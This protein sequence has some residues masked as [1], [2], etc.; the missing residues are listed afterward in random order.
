MKK[1]LFTIALS[2]AATALATDS[3]S[4]LYNGTNK[5]LG[6]PLSTSANSIALSS[7]LQNK[8]FSY[9][10]FFD[11]TAIK[12][13]LTDTTSTTTVLADYTSTGFDTSYAKTAWT[14]VCDST[15][16]ALRATAGTSSLTSTKVAGP[17][18]WTNLTQLALTVSFHENGSSYASS[19]TLTT[20][21]QATAD[22]TATYKS[23][24]STVK[25]GSSAW[26]FANK[27]G[28]TTDNDYKPSTL[29]LNTSY[30]NAAYVSSDGIENSTSRTTYA[31]NL[32]STYNSIP[33][34][35][36]ATLSLLALAGLAARRRRK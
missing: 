12:E 8:D 23:T 14:L 34:P 1:T 18:N 13:L 27:S 3:A 6:T 31:T 33:E 29:S 24:D 26:N 28:S 22:A 7:T 36:T 9:T 35:A 2:L 25:N 17:D 16:F 11:V 5:A 4:L 15:G 30:V 32:M 21:T 10:L 19:L 20:A